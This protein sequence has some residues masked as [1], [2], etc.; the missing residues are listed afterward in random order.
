MKGLREARKNAG[1]SQ[2]Q[3][4][5]KVSTSQRAIS[6]WEN[7][8][9]RYPASLDTVLRIARALKVEPLYFFKLL[10]TKCGEEN[11]KT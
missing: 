6:D 4:A 11:L 7:I 9:G 2:M 1:L 3:L 8:P 5:K 10:T